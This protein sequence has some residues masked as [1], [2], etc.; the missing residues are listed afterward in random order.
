MASGRS[1]EPAFDIVPTRLAMKAMRDNGYKNAAYAIAEL[2]DNAVQAKAKSVELLCKEDEELVT[3]RTRRR[4]QE[5]AVVDDGKGMTAD[6]LRK[7]LQFGNGERLDDRS[8]IGRF[9]MGLPNSSISQARRVDVWSWQNGFKSAIHSYLDLDEI[10][11]GDMGEVPAPSKTTIPKVWARHSATMSTSESGTLVVW[12]KLDRCDWRTAHAI[13][14]NSEFTIG[15]IYRRFI[16]RQKVRIRMAAF[17]DGASSCDF[18]E[19]VRAND[20]MYL[21]DGTSCPAPFDSEA[22]FEPYGEPHEIKTQIGKRIYTVTVRF[23]VAKKSA[24]S[25][26]NEGGTN[27]G[28]HAAN[29][30]GV[31]VMRADRELE[32]Q[33]DW[34][35]GFD[36]RERWWGV[37]VEFPPALDEIFGV[38]NNKQGARTLAE[39]AKLELSQIAS[40]EGYDSETE[41]RDEWTASNDARMVL[42]HVKASIENNL[43][44]IRKSIKAQA[45]RSRSQGRHKDPNSAEVRGTKATKERQEGGYEGSTDK[46]EKLPPAQREA[47]IAKDLTDQ[48]LSPGEAKDRATSIVSDGRKF[49]FYETDLHTPELFTVRGKTGAILIGLNTTHPGYA[50]LVELMKTDDTASL[51]ADELRDR[52]G[53]AYEGLKLLLEA[54]ARYEDELTDPRKKEQAQNTRLDW[55]RVA[56]DFFR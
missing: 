54:W 24:R 15:R 33:T 37:E 32:L 12:S 1:V 5:I 38:P 19:D 31:S 3:H 44:A 2:V 23:S 18:D 51:S 52:L 39:F 9:G 49:E 7:A 10:D 46:E 47:G 11:A 48:G 43:D 27:Y 41:L 25:G 42:V 20:P 6:I 21:M 56:R 30:V 36:T 22:M 45:E 16:A 34:C 50:H 17:M 35:I 55:G 13:F 28:K 29:N 14:K 40:R 4:V 53:Q 26:H 8:G